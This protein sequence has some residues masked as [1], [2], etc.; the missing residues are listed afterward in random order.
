MTAGQISG[1]IPNG[2]VSWDTGNENPERLG[3]AIATSRNSCNMAKYSLDE[4]RTEPSKW[5][6]CHSISRGFVLGSMLDGLKIGGV[7]DLI[8]S[9][10]VGFF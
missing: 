2:P 3:H 7:R 9:A 10:S 1:Q 6:K 4:T 5:R 8:L